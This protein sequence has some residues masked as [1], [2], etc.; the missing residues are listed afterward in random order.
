MSSQSSIQSIETPFGSDASEYSFFPIKHKSLHDLYQKQKT[1]FWVP[2]E[3]DFS[4]GDT[5]YSDLSPDIQ[6]FVK[7]ILFFFAQSDGI[8]IENLVENFKRD[9]SFIKEARYFYSMQEAIEVI[10]NETYSIL[11]ESYI[12]D[13]DEKRAGFNAINTYPSIQNIAKWV[14]QFMDPKTNSLLERVVAFAC[15][16]GIFFSGPFCSIY[17]LKRINALEGLIRANELIAP[18]E[19]LHVIGAGVIGRVL[20][21]DYHYE[22]IST[23][24]CHEIVKSAMDVS[25]TFIRDALHV[26]LIGMSADDMVAYVKCCANQVSAMFVDEPVFHVENPFV[27]MNQ[28]ALPNQTNFFE[29]RNLVYNRAHHEDAP[30]TDVF[31]SLDDVAF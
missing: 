17:W 30:D 29:R 11:I 31:D 10:H 13:P 2:G 14:F 6:R 15:V 1:M 3:I 9:T 12:K 23:K 21:H 5:H 25:E 24:R 27:W 4:D 8:V 20:V 19:A 18:D 22:P 28:I 16:E 26:D 7:F